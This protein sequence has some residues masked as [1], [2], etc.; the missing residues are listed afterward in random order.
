MTFNGNSLLHSNGSN[1]DAR[2]LFAGCIHKHKRQQI[3]CHIIPSGAHN[4]N[5]NVA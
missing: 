2:Q 3:Q 1:L 4:R 5:D